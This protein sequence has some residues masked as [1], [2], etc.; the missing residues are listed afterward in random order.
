MMHLAPSYFGQLQSRKL[1][2]TEGR[3]K[4]YVDL[5]SSPSVRVSIQ[6]NDDI[7]S[8]REPEQAEARRLHM[9][10]TTGG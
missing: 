7:A 4:P 1:L 5:F 6:E 8:E 9:Y 3:L 10:R 2:S